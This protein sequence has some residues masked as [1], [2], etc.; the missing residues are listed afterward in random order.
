L[1]LE[2]NMAQTDEQKA[3]VA[4]LCE[5]F[6][7]MDADTGQEIREA[8]HNTMDGLYALAELL[9]AEDAKQPE[10]A[11]PLLAEHLLAIEALDAMKQSRL[12]AI[13]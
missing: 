8:Y 3:T 13:V 2:V 1:V 6:R 12:G 9:E 10:S 5:I 11:G 7:T 4:Y